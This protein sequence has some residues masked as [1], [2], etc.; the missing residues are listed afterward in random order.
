M[1]RLCVVSVN[2]GRPRAIRHG[3]R[4]LLSG[5]DKRPVPGSV[6][7]TSAGLAGDAICDTAHHGGPDQ[8]VYVYSAA[9]YAWWSRELGRDVA[10]GTFGDNLTIDTMPSDLN[11][12][13]RLMI[14][15]VI[16]EATAPRIPCG[17]LAAMMQDTDFG[18]RFRRAERPGFYFRVLHEGD[19]STGDVVVLV[20]NPDDGISMLEQFRLSYELHPRAA[21]LRRALDAPIAERMLSLIHI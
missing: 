19:V 7:I 11:T 4:E 17:T 16:L 10:F 20:E 18:L 14:G 15:D 1:E 13:D 9:D 5:I 21:D 2:I 8:A 6:R 12:G 3:E